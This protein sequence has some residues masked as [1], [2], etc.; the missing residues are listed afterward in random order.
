MRERDPGVER[1]VQLAIPLVPGAASAPNVRSEL[2]VERV[3]GD[4]A[5]GDAAG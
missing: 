5:A 1:Q 3:F 4:Q 2:P